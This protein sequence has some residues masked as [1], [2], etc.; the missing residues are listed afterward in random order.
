MRLTVLGEAKD[1]I[2]GK[3]LVSAV[4]VVQT[5]VILPPQ[6]RPDTMDEVLVAG[7]AKADSPASGYGASGELEAFVYPSCKRHGNSR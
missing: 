4:P 6:P 1:V 3:S 7:E 5:K 2:N